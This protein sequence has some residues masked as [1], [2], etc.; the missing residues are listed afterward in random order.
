L[1]LLKNIERA[2]YTKMEVMLEYDIKPKRESGEERESSGYESSESEREK[3][4]PK[5]RGK[6]VAKS[7][8]DLSV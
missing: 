7:S 3:E 1:D 5:E 2:T 6:E 8:R 4:V